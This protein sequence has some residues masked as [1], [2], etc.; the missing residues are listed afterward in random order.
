MHRAISVD[1]VAGF[2]SQVE[3]LCRNDE[4]L[5]RGQPAT[6]KLLPRIAR[7]SFRHRGAT[8]LASEKGMIQHFRR[9]ALPLLDFRPTNDWEW[10]AVAQHYGTATRLLDWTQNPLAALWFAVHQPGEKGSQ[11]AVWYFEPEEADRP[12]PQRQPDP[13]RIRR[14]Y[15]F[16]PPH[17]AQRISRQAGWFTA[18]H[19]QTGGSRFMALDADPA[20]RKR[21]R[22]FVI[23][24]NAFATIRATLDRCGI[25]RANLMADL[26]G[27]ARH[28]DWLHSRMKDEF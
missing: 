12:R 26:E 9:R 6:E 17:I 3:S 13:F 14:T 16:Q 8:L 22:L 10:L 19:W 25:N 5:F 15:V 27:L 11:A 21:L 23:P 1:T 20:Y 2:L 18:H 28:I 4:V 7:R 24:A